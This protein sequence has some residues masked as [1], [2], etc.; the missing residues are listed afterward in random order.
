MLL[1]IKNIGKIKAA[2]IELNGITVIGGEN[3]TGKSTVGKVLFCMINSFYNIEEQIFRERKERIN[4]ILQIESR[5]FIG[6]YVD[7][8]L[9]AEEIIANKDE[10]MN[11]IE[12]MSE[13]IFTYFAEQKHDL[14]MRLDDLDSIAEQIIKVLEISNSE[15]LR[16][17]LGK[18]LK[19]E[20]NGQ[21][22]NVFEE[23]SLAEI[24]LN[25]RNIDFNVLIQKD[26][27]LE[28]NNNISLQN[29]VIYIDDPF[30]LDELNLLGLYFV[31]PLNT[32]MSHRVHLGAKLS[33]LN[34]NIDIKDVMTEIL[35]KNRILKVLDKLDE[36]CGGTI[37]PGKHSRV[38]YKLQNSDKTLSVRSLSTGLKSFIIIKTLLENGSITED[39]VVILDE[40]EI[41]L[42]PQW[43]LV[44]AELIVLLQEEFNLHILLNTHSPYFLEAIEV[45]SKKHNISEKC[46]YYLAENTGDG[47]AEILDVTDNIELIYKKLAEPF[48]TLEDVEYIND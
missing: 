34:N 17:I 31:K 2:D 23:E 39:G 27:V 35:V 42:H 36:I 4:Y 38:V 8:G 41:H 18:K 5:S 40:P 29:D 48:Q 9:A 26:E 45:Y 15:I 24:N 19:A 30:I 47:Q 22:N 25:I 16:T 14:S 1:K 10:Y 13:N 21:I 37:I 12:K 46:K 43:Q 44:L 6:D 11:D 33:N 28:I 32:A 20:F 7:F 3:N